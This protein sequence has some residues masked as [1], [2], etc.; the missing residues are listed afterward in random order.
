MANCKNENE[1]ETARKRE[2]ENEIG[3]ERG[4][5]ERESERVRD[6]ERERV[7]WRQR[8]ELNTCIRHKLHVQAHHIALWIKNTRKTANDP[9]IGLVLAIWTMLTF[10][11]VVVSVGPKNRTN[12][13]PLHIRNLDLLS[14][15]TCSL[16][17]THTRAHPLA[18]SCS[19]SRLPLYRLSFP[20]HNFHC[21]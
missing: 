4:K 12:S 11:I 2:N 6:K 10:R 16:T 9:T 20:L 13:S 19:L 5:R 8:E 7:M 17:H 18:P 15:I 21:M 1:T 14:P 3:R